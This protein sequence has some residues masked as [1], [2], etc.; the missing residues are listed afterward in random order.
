MSYSLFYEILNVAFKFIF[1][2]KKPR[3]N[4]SY[5]AFFIEI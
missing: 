5:E 3:K 2:I 4:I 1:Q